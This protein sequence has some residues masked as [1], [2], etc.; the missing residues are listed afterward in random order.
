MW[1]RRGVKA[2]LA[3]ALVLGISAGPSVFASPRP[4]RAANPAARVIAK[5][6]DRIPE[7]M[8]R[9][10]VPGLAVALVDRQ[11]A[12]WVQGFGQRDDSGNPVT[13]DTIFSVQSMS[14]TFTATAVMR[15]V[16]AGRLDLDAPITRY[17]PGFTVHSAFEKHPERKITLRMLLSHTAGFTHEA[18]VGNNNDLDPGTFD[19]HVR[20]IS[21]TWL[22][23]PVGAGYAYSN[24][25]IDLAGYILE[26]VEG[27]PFAT[28]M[29]DSLLRPLGMSHSTFDRSAIRARDNRAQGH[30]R[31]YPA[32]PLVVPMT[33]AGG[34]YTSAAD[35]ARFLRFELNDGSVNGQVVLAPKWMHEMRTIP[36]PNAG[37]PA[38]YALGV[39]RTRWNRFDQ[40]PDLFLHGGG[41]FGF[42][43]D[44]WWAPQLQVGVAILTN[45]QDH[46]LQETL[47]L[48][49]LA[50]LVTGP[51]V[52]RDR[53]LGLPRRPS[54]ME[55]SGSFDPPF[56]TAAL[57]ARAAMRRSGHEATLWAAY[58]G[59][60]RMPQWGMIAP[61]GPT[62]RFL[63]D[64]GSP[65]FET[66][67]DSDTLVRHALVEVKPGLF[68]SDD[69][70]MLDMRGK[71]PTWRNLPLV[72]VAVSPAG[73]QWVILAST[74]VVAAAWLLAAAVRARRRRQPPSA[75][76]QPAAQHRRWRQTTGV[77]AA[78]TAIAALATV[79]L[80]AALPGVVDSGFLGWL[81]LPVAARLAAHLPLTLAALSV[82]TVALASWGWVGHWWSDAVRL[83]Y[84]ALA[85]AATTLVTQMAAWRLIGWGYT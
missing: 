11:R 21:G 8:A 29:R 6:R 65:Y 2:A 24:L 75:S 50:D 30:V 9:Q 17:V 68:L 81:D 34:L 48:S 26:R 58:S 3:V 59:L 49:I 27:K 36:S 82:C 19:A 85:V 46:Q 47:A 23:F 5:Y 84:T 71:T 69:G 61:V 73:W 60:Y 38:G 12:L 56:G 45:S 64:A 7:L 83:Q 25:G 1:W 28:L 22:R 13:G 70:E 78:A 80:V 43:S 51:G 14:K 55:P 62:D 31:P 52:Y 32:P 20:S 72:R 57:I 16:A 63:I 76:T 4:V 33:A 53:L 67:D 79:A 54:V 40:R 42:L 35:L 41:G 39:A 66:Q 77:V 37:A 44:L 18:P 15:A 10:H 74:A